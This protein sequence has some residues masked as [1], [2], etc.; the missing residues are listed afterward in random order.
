MTTNKPTADG[1]ASDKDQTDQHDHNNNDDE[2]QP[3]KLTSGPTVEFSV[4]FDEVDAADADTS[5][6][7]TSD[8]D[9]D[10]GRSSDGTVTHKSSPVAIVSVS[11]TKNTNEDEADKDESDD[12]ASELDA[13]LDTADEDDV[14]LRSYPTFA[15]DHVTVINR[16]SNRRLL[17][18]VNWSFY[19]R[20]LTAIAVDDSDEE[21][22]TALLATL[23]GFRAP[24]TGEITLKSV[25]LNS[26]DTSELRGHRITLI[27]RHFDLRNDLDA[28]SNLVL[29]MD[30][31]GRTFLKPKPRIA[32]EL[33][34]EVGFQEEIEGVRAGQF[35]EADRR[36]IGI[37]RAFALEST[38][39]VIDGPTEGLED[40]DRK[41]ILD[42]LNRLAHS[43]DPR[44]CVVMVT[45][46]DKDMDAADQVVKL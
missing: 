37:A 34:D 40:D 45:S 29:A 7:D 35:H 4:V 12:T 41:A 43:R 15:F 3:T 44:R 18:E 36:R 23:G 42:L 16:K 22:H 1:Q 11:G 5:D 2:E 9:A 6:R 19:E 31:S 25:A 39:T 24:D 46:S 32:R 33:L 21:Q 17:D 10:A 13:D 28:V 38:V 27:P 30:A 26:F 14:L 20:T 8:A